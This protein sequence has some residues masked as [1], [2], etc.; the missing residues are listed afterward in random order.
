MFKNTIN[1][2]LSGKDL[3]DIEAKELMDSMMEGNL[4]DSENNWTT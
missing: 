4:T 3:S 2:I 1:Q